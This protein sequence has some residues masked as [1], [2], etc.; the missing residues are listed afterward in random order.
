MSLPAKS[1]RLKRKAEEL[2]F[3]LTKYRRIITDNFSSYSFS[4]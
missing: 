4:A 3:V 2:Q 1:D